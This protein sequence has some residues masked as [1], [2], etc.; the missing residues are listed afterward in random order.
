MEATDFN[1][2]AKI[3]HK[4]IWKYI[5]ILR[6]LTVKIQREGKSTTHTL[7]NLIISS[8]IKTKACCS[9]FCKHG[10][11]YD[12]N[13]F[14]TSMLLTTACIYKSLKSKSYIQNK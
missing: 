13:V 11:K 5:D 8:K 1:L 9:H 10:A 6:S 4:L 2:I 14:L 3:T 7:H 12:K